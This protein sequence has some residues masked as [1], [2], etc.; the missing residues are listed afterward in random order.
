MARDL[1]FIPTIDV[2]VLLINAGQGSRFG[3]ADIMENLET[4][5]ALCGGKL[6]WDNVVIVLTKVDYNPM[7]YDDVDEWKEE[8]K[9]K[10]DEVKTIVMNKYGKEVLGVIAISQ[11]L[12]MKDPRKPMESNTLDTLHEKFNVL[13]NLT[14][15]CKGY[16]T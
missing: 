7:N 13:K 9:E 2:F 1:K 16:G 6:M 15:S 10:E 12:K 11:A 5:Q 8:L 4:Y 3:S 14:L